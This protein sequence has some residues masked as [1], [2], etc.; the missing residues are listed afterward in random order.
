MT[1]TPKYAKTTTL[2]RDVRVGDRID[3]AGK[4]RVA[5]R[6]ERGDAVL[7]GLKTNGARSG[8]VARF[9]LDEQVTVYR[10]IS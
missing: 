7:L 8:S 4:T 2:G 1:S 6:H 5:K 10:A 9:G 3:M